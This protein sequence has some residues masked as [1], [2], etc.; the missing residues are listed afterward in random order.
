MKTMVRTVIVSV[1]VS[2]I[3]M[4]LSA[5][6][7][8]QRIEARM[9]ADRVVVEID[10]NVFTEYLFSAEHKYP[11]FY[12]VVGPASGETITTWNQSPFP[13][14]SSLYL[15][16]DHVRSGNV[17][18]HANY[19]QP[20]DDLSTGHVLSRQPEILASDGDAVV[21]RDRTE[22]VVPKDDHAHQLSDVRTIRITAPSPNIRL[23]DFQFELTP[24][25]YLRVGPTGHS[26]FSVRVRPE[27]A[28]GSPRMAAGLTSVATGTI[29]DSRG[30]RNE[31]EIR[32]K[33]ADWV[34]KYGTI[35]GHKEGI[36]IIQH[37]DNPLSPAKWF[38]RDYGFMSPTPFAFDGPISMNQGETWTFR[39]R[40]VVF[41]GDPDWVDIPA[42][43]RDFEDAHQ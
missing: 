4:A 41:S 13:H 20:R 25:V 8:T 18:G 21:L 42:L 2:T 29:I 17:Q 23:L 40:V 37:S 28:V 12:P 36:A 32:E 15:S 5:T 31:A 10:G 33:K 27:L 7:A 24:E 16:L 14:H 6:A 39:Y 1:I 22:W 9:E 11:F 3:L 35:N 34:T 19:W 30:G 38:I 43:K 26:F